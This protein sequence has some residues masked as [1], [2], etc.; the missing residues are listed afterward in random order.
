M[1]RKLKRGLDY[2]PLDVDFWQDP[3]FQ[4]VEAKF[5]IKGGYIAIRLLCKIY[6]DGYYT[7]WN[8]DIALLFAS[9]DIG[10][11]TAN[12][13]SDV[14]EELVRRGFF[15][16]AI[17]NRFDVLTSGAIQTRYLSAVS[18]RKEVEIN[19]NYWLI[20]VPENTKTTRFFISRPENDINPPGNNENLPTNPQS[21][22]EE[23]K[24]KDK[25]L[26]LSE[27]AP[28]EAKPPKA[29]PNKMFADNSAEMQL[30]VLLFDL[31][32]Q[33]NPDCKEPSLQGWCK[34]IDLMLRIDKRTPEQIREIIKF[35][36]KDSF[37]RANVLS[38]K[39]LR[40]QFDRLTVKA[41]SLPVL[42]VAAGGASTNPFL[43][44]DI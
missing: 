35:S 5:G 11:V 30:S 15:D 36:Q 41:K 33:N 44:E 43:R 10:N 16:E 18:E 32:R 42:Q 40:E 2:F 25:D 4:F 20:D 24:V 34:H 17:L 1:G 28:D 37:W 22:V 27:Q 29:L 7:Q 19:M 21:K 8:E 31:M 13:V 12:L 3:K 26:S 23:S 9:R 14:V 6:R 39:K 38:T